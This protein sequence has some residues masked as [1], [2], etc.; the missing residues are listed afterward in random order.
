V[1][2][3]PDQPANPHGSSRVGPGH[4][5]V[6]STRQP[7]RPI[8]CGPGAGSGPPLYPGRAQVGLMRPMARASGARVSAR[9]AG[10]ASSPTSSVAHLHSSRPLPSPTFVVSPPTSSTG[11]QLFF[12]NYKKNMLLLIFEAKISRV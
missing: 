7:A 3:R 8:S 4:E 1:R 2:I 10:A 11:H 5:S 6:G 9:P 12:S